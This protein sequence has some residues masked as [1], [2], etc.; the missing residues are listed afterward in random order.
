MLNLIELLDKNG[1]V[2]RLFNNI[3]FR[4]NP[5]LFTI[6]QY[7]QLRRQKLIPA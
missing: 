4:A 7:L 2:C 5:L 1:E 3:E 6:A